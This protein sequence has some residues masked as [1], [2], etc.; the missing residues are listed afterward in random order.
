MGEKAN[1]YLI[2]VHE[3]FQKWW[4][5]V[6][7]IIEESCDPRPL[8][9]T[10]KDVQQEVQRKGEAIKEIQQK[11]IEIDNQEKTIRRANEDLLK[12][13]AQLLKAKKVVDKLNADIQEIK[14]IEENYKPEV[15]KQAFENTLKSEEST[16][17]AI[18]SSIEV[19]GRHA[20]SH[21]LASR[22]LL[23]Y[24]LKIVEAFS[25]V[26]KRTRTAALQKAGRLSDQA[27]IAYDNYT[28]AVD[29]LEEAIGEYLHARDGNSLINHDD[30]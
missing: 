24:D 18:E 4:S 9:A 8:E 29:E 10:L 25:A 6:S 12:H 19:I 30:K 2:T 17:I 14:G 1:E 15:I 11:K 3:P 16:M 22:E 5:K 7:P 21:H 20:S 28:Q 13:E 23:L 27:R 26:E